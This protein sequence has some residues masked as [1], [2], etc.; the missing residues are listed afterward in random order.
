MTPSKTTVPIA[1]SIRHFLTRADLR[2]LCQQVNQVQYLEWRGDHLD[3]LGPCYS[4]AQQLGWQQIY[5]LRSREEGGQF[6]GSLSARHQQLI[7]MAPKVE[8]VELEAERDLSPAIL[9]AIPAH[10]R[11]IAWHGPVENP[12][13]LAT[14]LH[15]YRQTPAAFYKII[16]EVSRSGE[17]VDILAFLKSQKDEKLITYAAGP[18][19]RWTQILA[20][21]WGSAIMYAEAQASQPNGEYFPLN[22]LVLDYD[23]P[24]LRPFNYLAGIVGNPVFTSLSPRLH[25]TTYRQLG[26]DCLYLPFHIESYDDFWEELIN[27][28]Y[29]G[30]Q[31]L[32]FIG[33]TVVS[34]F[35]EEGVRRAD[36]SRQA[37]IEHTAAANV[38]VKNGHHWTSDTTDF[39]GV[40][41]VLAHLEVAARNLR[42]AIIGCGGAGRTMAAGLKAAGAAV[43]LVNRSAGRAQFASDQ[44]A[45]RH[46]L[47][48]DFSPKGFD[49]LI[50]ATPLG[51]QAGE[52]PF[53]PILS[54]PSAIIIDMAYGKQKTRL[55]REAEIAGRMVISGIDILVLQ[56]QQQFKLMTGQVMPADL[57]YRLAGA[58]K[59]TLFSPYLLEKAEYKNRQ[60]AVQ[61]ER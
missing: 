51:K 35:K 47:L 8:L 19:G 17:E 1:V 43:T 42:V 57:A 9:Q 55:V 59:G 60:Y 20:A 61:Q 29:E 23:L 3:Q 32:N 15:R 21:H 31:L 56:V 10:K 2:Y 7:A 5:A 13:A 24:H 34:P 4:F 53:N 27:Y 26:L 41:E 48:E 40:S 30:Q 37:I 38:V 44:L 14:R 58:T 46:C 50:N 16:P 22:R 28:P 45:L 6:D 25:N 33:F 49:L 36:F 39:Y 52:I 12:F 11:I 54:D 18:I